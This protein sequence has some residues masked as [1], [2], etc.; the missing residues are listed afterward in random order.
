MPH[1]W[2]CRSLHGM[3]GG[4]VAVVMIGVAAPAAAGPIAAVTAD[5]DGDGIV[6]DIQLTEAGVV[7]SPSQ[8]HKPVTFALAATRGRIT[9]DGSWIA[10]EVDGADSVE[11]IGLRYK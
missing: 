6:D 4:L 3:R 10:V 11:G 1:G 8:A 7:V 5:V 2:R 9:A